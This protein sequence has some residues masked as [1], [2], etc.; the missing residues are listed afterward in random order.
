MNG[1]IYL[2][3]V[4]PNTPGERG[5]PKVSVENSFLSQQGLSEDFNVYRTEKKAG[6]LNRAILIF[7]LETIQQ[8]NMEGWPI[9]AGHLGENITTT[10]ISYDA[11]AVGTRW[12]IDDA[13]VEISEICNPCKNLRVLPYVGLTRIIPFVATLVGRR[14][15]YARILQEGNIQRGAEIKSL[16]L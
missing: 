12:K 14:G 7:P 1:L 15:W 5:I 8:L 9:E 11:L 4:K 10:G 6:T 16:A 3:T 2:L 13:K